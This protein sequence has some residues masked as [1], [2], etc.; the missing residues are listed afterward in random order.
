MR[1]N[2]QLALLRSV[3]VLLIAIGVALLCFLGV[4]FWE[5]VLWLIFAPLAIGSLYAGWKMCRPSKATARAVIYWAI[6]VLW[7]L[8]FVMISFKDVTLI[9]GVTAAIF[10]AS[11]VGAVYVLVQKS[12]VSN[13]GVLS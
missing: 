2:I 8:A 12:V 7:V 10:A 3:G 4:W 5:V 1:N 6:S 13:P 9:G 11:V